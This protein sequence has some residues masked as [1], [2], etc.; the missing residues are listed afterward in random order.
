MTAYISDTSSS[1]LGTSLVQTAYDRS[2]EFVLRASP[3]FRDFADKQPVQQAMPGSAVVIQ[4]APQFTEATSTLTELSDVETVRLGNTTPVTITLGEYGNATK[5]TS[6]LKLT[7]LA[8][9]DPIISQAIAN[10]MLDSLDTVYQ[11]VLRGGSQ[12]VRQNGG[13]FTV[14]GATASVA[15]TDTAILKDFTAPVAKMRAGSV[16]PWAGG[17]YFAVVHPLVAFDLRSTSGQGGWLTPNE[18]GSSQ[19]RI[20]AGE[21]GKVGGARF[22]ENPRCYNTTDG[23]SSARVY[24]SYVIGKQA[25]AEAIALAPQIVI[26]PQTDALR[27]FDTIGWKA[28]LGTS[29]FRS[30]A[31]WRVETA[32]SL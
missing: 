11:T 31:L 9:V 32:A 4:I 12:V 23:A 28:V 24:R 14:G 6:M 18:Y 15:S 10:N 21:V 3:M 25:L 7:S 29:L 17:D 22:I 13:N 8:A 5:T 30:T 19:D 26:G 20:W 2:V 27:R 16:V 1:S